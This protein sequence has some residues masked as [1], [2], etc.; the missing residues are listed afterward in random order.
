MDAYTTLKND[1][2]QMMDTAENRK[3]YCPF[4]T[5]MTLDKSNGVA[6]E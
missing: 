4:K 5:C 1:F 3:K 2:L 6:I